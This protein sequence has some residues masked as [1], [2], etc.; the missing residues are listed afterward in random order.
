M[1]MGKRSKGAQDPKGAL[2]S[3]GVDRQRGRE[4]FL[5]GALESWRD[6]GQRG[7]DGVLEGVALR[8][9]V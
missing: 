9:R 1:E 5:R 6:D 7:R 2:E 4:G 8:P 3:R